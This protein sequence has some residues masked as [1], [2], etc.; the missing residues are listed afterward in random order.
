MKIKQNYIQ[1]II[2]LEFYELMKQF[3]LKRLL[4]FQ[5]FGYCYFLRDLSKKKSQK[6]NSFK[7][8]LDKHFIC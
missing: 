2:K 6:F 8:I 3:K 7:L 5:F 4:C 1:I